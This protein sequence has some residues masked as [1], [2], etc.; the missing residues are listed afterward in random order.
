MEDSVQIIT[1]EIVGRSFRVIGDEM[2]EYYS[3]VQSKSRFPLRGND[4]L[5]AKIVKLLSFCVHIIH[6]IW[7]EI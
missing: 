3:K 2:N 4:C 6:A 7:M 1:P 5:C